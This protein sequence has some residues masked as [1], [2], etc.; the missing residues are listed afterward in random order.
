MTELAATYWCEHAWLGDPTAGVQAGVAL[1]IDGDRVVDVH[2]DV[3][4]PPRS[5]ELLSGLTVPGFANA[6]SHAFHRA[7]RGR[8]H[9]AAGSF[10]TWRDQMYDLAGRLDPDRL[11]ALARATFGEMALAG[12]TCV[13]EFHYLHNDSGGATYADPNAMASAVQQ[14]ATE[15]GVR[16]TLLDACYLDGGFGAA[17]ERAQQRFIDPDPTVWVQ[18]VDALTPSTTFRVA[19]AV[20]SVRAVDPAA[21]EVVAA[22][23]EGRAAPLHAHVSE[24]PAENEQCLAAH[25]CTP[26]ELLF[27]HG[28]LSDRFTAVHATHV[29]DDDLARLTS[30]GAMGCFCPTTERDLADGIG[31]SAAL[32]AAGVSLCLGTDSHAVIDPFEEA[33]AVELDERLRSHQRGTHSPPELLTMATGAGYRSLGWPEG[34]RIEAGALADLTTIGLD[35]VRL[36]GTD[37]AAVDAAVV[38]GATSTDVRQVMMGGQVIVRDGV[39]VRLD[40]ARELQRSIEAAWA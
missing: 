24:Q 26:T 16:L 6:H 38:F 27:R 37:L 1:T 3:A 20:H 4:H 30:A 2:T 40:V 13:G 15:A 11:R 17:P 39:H 34:G 23:A 8:T 36:A 31:P 18:R 35:S 33:R 14:A 12:F 10:W 22:W 29:T 9:G 25:G 28:A 5:A 7:L 19:A 32:C 21:I